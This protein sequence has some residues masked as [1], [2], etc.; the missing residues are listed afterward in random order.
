M[1]KLWN[2][3]ACYCSR[4]GKKIHPHIYIKNMTSFNILSVNYILPFCDS[5]KDLLNEGRE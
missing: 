5:C 2:Y 4:C 3:K 1:E